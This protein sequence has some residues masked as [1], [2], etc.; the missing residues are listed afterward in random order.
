MHGIEP[1]LKT[2][3]RPRQSNAS[4]SKII[5]LSLSNVET[6]NNERGLIHSWK[7]NEN[8]TITCPT[9]GCGK[10]L[11][12]LVT[13]FPDDWVTELVEKAEKIAKVISL[14]ESTSSTSD[15]RCSCF[16]SEGQVCRSNG[17]LT[18]AASREDSTDNYLYNPSAVELRPEDLKHFQRHWAKGEPVIVSNVL[19]SACGLSWE[20]M[21]MW[22]AFRQITNLNHDRHLDVSAVDCLDI[23]EVSLFDTYFFLYIYN[24]RLKLS[25]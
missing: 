3:R 18:K 2:S 19:A 13:M 5:K 14:V 8:G 22:R 17:Q 15:E 9:I 21:V 4:P 7:A 1:S 25:F 10:D 20:P 16:K 11:L 24:L 12:E 6:K 23:C